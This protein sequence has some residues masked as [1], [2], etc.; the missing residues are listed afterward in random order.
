MKSV[1]DYVMPLSGRRLQSPCG[2]E[3]GCWE[4]F[5]RAIDANNE[6]AA[7][8]RGFDELDLFLHAQ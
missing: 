4:L 6:A 8:L 7:T 5:N 3:K 1:E 2:I